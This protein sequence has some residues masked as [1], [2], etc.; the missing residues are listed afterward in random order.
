MKT[1][2][3]EFNLS[4]KIDEWLDRKQRDG[5]L[6]ELVAPKRFEDLEKILKE[7]I[8]RLKEKIFSPIFD[9]SIKSQ[10]QIEQELLFWIDKLAGDKLT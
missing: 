2:K 9:S 6:R 1:E 10:S 7:F 8:K 3:K 5:S 4:E